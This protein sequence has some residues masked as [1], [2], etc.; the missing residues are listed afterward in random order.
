MIFKFDATVQLNK[1]LSS[2]FKNESTTYVSSA[3]LNYNFVHSYKLLNHQFTQ[4]LKMVVDG[5]FNYISPTLFLT[6]VLEIFERP[7]KI[8]Q[9]YLTCGLE[10][11]ERPNK[12]KSTLIG[13]ENDN[14]GA[15]SPKSL[16]WWLKANLIIYHQHKFVLMTLK[17]VHL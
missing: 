17:I 5:K 2:F 11:F 9:F 13:E 8:N 12:W 10:I 7:N 15:N 4:K 1:C 14:A 3:A 16:S 6:C